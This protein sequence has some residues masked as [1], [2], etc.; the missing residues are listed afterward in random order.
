MQ[1]RLRRRA[2]YPASWHEGNAKVDE[3]AKAAALGINISA[4]LLGRCRQHVAEA[5]RFVGVLG[6]GCRRG[7]G[8]QTVEQ[9]RTAPVGPQACRDG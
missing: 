4:E 3:A 5:E 6:A 2:N 9:S 7:P 8:R 1:R